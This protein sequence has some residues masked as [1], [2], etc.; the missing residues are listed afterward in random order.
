MIG[1]YP[2]SEELKKIIEG[3]G[4]TLYDGGCVNP[5][6]EP[7]NKSYSWEEM[8][9]MGPADVYE[10]W[11][12]YV[13][14]PILKDGQSLLDAQK[15]TMGLGPSLRI[16]NPEDSRWL[17]TSSVDKNNALFTKLCFSEGCIFATS[18]KTIYNPRP[19]TVAIDYDFL[20]DTFEK[21]FK[22]MT[23]EELGFEDPFSKHLKNYNAS[24]N[25]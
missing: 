16:D 7:K 11:H 1:V 5:L 9:K 8:E 25:N 15:I 13:F 19:D 4:W 6:T 23:P 3:H 21:Y 12:Y 22:I 10:V 24:I 17:Y 2:R 14:M 18:P 20:I